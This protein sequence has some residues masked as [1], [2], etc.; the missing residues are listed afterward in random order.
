MGVQEVRWERGGTEPTTNI[1][2]S[3]ESGKR[4]IDFYRF[5]V[6][7]VIRSAIMG[8]DIIILRSHWCD[9]IV[10]NVH[11]STQQKIDDMKEN[12][13]F[14]ISK[15]TIWKFCSETALSK[16]MRIYAKFILIVNFV[17]MKNL[18][19]VQCSHIAICKYVLGHFQ[20]ERITVGSK[21][22]WHTV[23]GIQLCLIFSISG[24]QT[25]I[26]TA[27]QWR[28]DPWQWVNKQCNQNISLVSSMLL[29]LKWRYDKIILEWHNIVWGREVSKSDV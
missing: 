18:S 4:I 19:K 14:I 10:L 27:V 11:T 24:E 22:F 15:N 26:L 3:L 2:L 21:M 20:K 25:E 16:G 29:S 7:K 8:V 9:I 5:V 1:H 12:V 28:P 6:H 23:N 17:T 13:Y